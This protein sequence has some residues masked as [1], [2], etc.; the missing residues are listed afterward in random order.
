M[1]TRRLHT[2]VVDWGPADFKEWMTE[3]DEV[4]EMVRMMTEKKGDADA[5]RAAEIIVEMMLRAFRAGGKSFAAAIERESLRRLA[6][7]DVARGNLPS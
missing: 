6:A 3:D 4:C 5:Q 7:D 2:I 1:T